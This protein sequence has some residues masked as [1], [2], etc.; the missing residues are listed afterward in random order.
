MLSWINLSSHSFEESWWGFLM[1][2]VNTCSAA[3]CYADLAWWRRTSRHVSLRVDLLTAIITV[4][5]LAIYI[6]NY[7]EQPLVAS[8]MLTGLKIALQRRVTS[9]EGLSSKRT[10]QFKQGCQIKL[11][12]SGKDQI[13]LKSYSSFDKQHTKYHGNVQKCIYGSTKTLVSRPNI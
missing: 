8:C 5:G 6:A 3:P 1:T 9:Q 4:L 11:C 13:K 7:S 2:V 10:A 12:P